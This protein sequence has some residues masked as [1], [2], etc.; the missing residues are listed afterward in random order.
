VY[1]DI[2][3][4]AAT[5]GLKVCKGDYQIFFHRIIIIIFFLSITFTVHYSK[6]KNNSSTIVGFVLLG[7][8]NNILTIPKH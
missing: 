2:N 8:K 4:H 7:I 5:G 1:A 6:A 3:D